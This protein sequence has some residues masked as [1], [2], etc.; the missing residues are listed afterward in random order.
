MRAACICAAFLCAAAFHIRNGGGISEKRT[1][2]TKAAKCRA[3]FRRSF[4]LW[5][6]ALRFA[7]GLWHR[8]RHQAAACVPFPYLCGLCLW[9]FAFGG[10]WP[11]L[12]SVSERRR[13]V[14]G[15][16]ISHGGGTDKGTAAAFLCFVLIFKDSSACLFRKES[17][18]AAAFLCAA[19]SGG[20][21]LCCGGLCGLCLCCGVLCG[22]CL[23]RLCLCFGGIGGGLCAFGLCLCG[24][25][26]LCAAFHIIYICGL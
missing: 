12:R 4:G 13:P 9:R 21:G 20:G 23:C 6:R 26:G 8:R 18:T 16:C 11:V 5:R 7:C 2:K 22:L 17:R 14:C 1:Q 25:G 19:A 10:L 15:L 3:A 24:G